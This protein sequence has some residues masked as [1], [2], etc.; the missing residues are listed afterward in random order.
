MNVVRDGRN[1]LLMRAPEGDA[2][3]QDVGVQ[4]LTMPEGTFYITR[5][6]PTEEELKVLA[7]GGVVELWCKGGMVP[8]ALQAAE[9]NEG[10]F[11]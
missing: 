2:N 8:V 4:K 1:N 5:W 3:T 10:M 7:S 9:Q 6:R 11:H